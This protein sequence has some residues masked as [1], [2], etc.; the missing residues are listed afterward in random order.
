MT[1]IFLVILLLLRYLCET[2]VYVA[3]REKGGGAYVAHEMCGVSGEIILFHSF[4]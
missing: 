1:F 3:M 2:L 4:V